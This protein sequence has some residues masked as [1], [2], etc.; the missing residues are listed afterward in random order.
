MKRIKLRQIIKVFALITY[1]IGILYLSKNTLTYENILEKR[2]ELGRNL[3]INNLLIGFVVALNIHSTGQILISYIKRGYYQKQKEIIILNLIFGVIF[4]GIVG[5]FLALAPFLN[6][7]IKILIFTLPTLFIIF[8]SKLSVGFFK[9]KRTQFIEICLIVAI[10]IINILPVWSSGGD[11]FEHYLPYMNEVY[12]NQ[13]TMPND[14]WYHFDL[15]RS[16]GLTMIGVIGFG[17]LTFQI[18]NSIL[19]I[20]TLM[21]VLKVI[22]TIIKIKLLS[23]VL[24]VP[25]SFLILPR[26]PFT[27]AF[28]PELLRHQFNNIFIIASLIL[29]LLLYY[30]NTQA[31]RNIEKTLILMICFYIGISS[32]ISVVY[33]SIFFMILYI[34]NIHLANIRRDIYRNLGVMIGGLLTQLTI[35]WFTAGYLVSAFLKPF[36]EFSN[37]TEFFSKFGELPFAYFYTQLDLIQPAERIQTSLANNLFPYLYIMI[38]NNLHNI[39]KYWIFV[40]VLLIAFIIDYKKVL[41]FKSNFQYDQNMFKVLASLFLAWIPINL[42]FGATGSTMRNSVMV[43]PVIYVI[44]IVLFKIIYQFIR[45]NLRVNL[46]FFLVILLIFN[47]GSSLFNLIEKRMVGIYSTVKYDDFRNSFVDDNQIGIIKNIDA[48]APM[49]NDSVK[50]YYLGYSPN[51]VYSAFGRKLI[52]EPSNI[53]DKNLRLKNIFSTN[54]YLAREELT[55]KGITSFVLDSTSKAMP[56]IGLSKALKDP[57]FFN[58][59]SCQEDFIHIDIRNKSLEP[60]GTQLYQGLVEAQTSLYFSEIYDYPRL[61]ETIQNANRI[62]LNRDT[63]LKSKKR[64]N[65]IETRYNKEIIVEFDKYIFLLSQS[66]KSIKDQSYEDFLDNLKLEFSSIF[67]DIYKFQDSAIICNNIEKLKENVLIGVL[68]WPVDD[69]KLLYLDPQ[70]LLDLFDN[71]I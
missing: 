63:I 64:L 57:L 43:Y 32:I 18:I 41:N 48:I 59:K 38:A 2:N 23:Y 15:S 6:R 30:K 68:N 3:V 17:P 55:N 71:S 42:A 56:G 26:H 25:F 16:F 45:V 39:Y 14:L 49:L 27:N 10:F 24:I 66:N 12:L 20:F 31:K 47:Y 37:K 28:A 60:A 8:K 35:S 13:N 61:F 44:L 36:W 69:Q 11:G 50:T 46:N 19:F 22:N 5:S 9:I 33:I 62:N 52:S 65:Y 1:V 58:I 40:L 7:E 53:V 34:F 21:I 4:W 70:R 54:S 51:L 29:I 67:M